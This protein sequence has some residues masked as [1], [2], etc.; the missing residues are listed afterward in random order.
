MWLTTNYVLLS[1]SLELYIDKIVMY[2][3]S[4][5][6]CVTIVLFYVW[7]YICKEVSC[8]L[9]QDWCRFSIQYIFNEIMCFIVVYE[10]SSWIIW[11]R[12]GM[13][14][15]D[16]QDTLYASYKKSIT[17]KFHETKYNPKQSYMC[18]GTHRNRK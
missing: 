7:S 10:V 14:N 15:M 11:V 4:W 1:A 18:I 17:I 3:F 9:T 6:D 13:K 8:V 5:N 12:K 16:H 2:I